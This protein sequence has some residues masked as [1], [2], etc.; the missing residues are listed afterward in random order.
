M[1]G[2]IRIGI[3]GWRYVPWRGQFYP[4]GLVQK[5]ELEFASRAVNTI[6]IN[7]S[8]YALQTPERYA[9]WYTDTPK[10]FIFS[11]KAPRYITH[12]KRLRDIE[13]PLANFF[14]S[15][16]FQLKE[17]LGPFLWQ[18]PPSLKFDK[19]LFAH[20]LQALPHTGAKAKACAQ[21][22]AQRMVT[23]GYLDIKPRQRLRHAV[24]IRHDSF[25]T[26]EFIELLRKFNI[27]LVV[28]DTAG[29]W[30]RLEDVTGDFVYMRLHG[31]T[32]LYK[33]G[34]S[35][36]ALTYWQARIEAWHRGT[37]PK[38]AQLAGG[39][40]G[41]RGGRRGGRRGSGKS[42]SAR[43]I[44]CYFD[45]TDKLWAPGDARTLLTRLGL[46]EQIAPDLDKL[47]GALTQ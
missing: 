43:D 18:F 16:V 7:G 38:D 40:G 32:E 39:R 12:I 42:A 46:G 30:P 17:K 20:F 25:I 47:A 27:A 14:A 37:Q 41:Q 1:S 4:K 35:S 44:Y 36:E 45:N 10:D 15:G 23:D 34:Y 6:E 8:F 33:S 31:D 24:E 28:A 26:E 19:E 2:D 21:H 29:R 22:C 11:V 13:E 3:S 9:R 5:R